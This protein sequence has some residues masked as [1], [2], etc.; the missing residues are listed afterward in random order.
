MSFERTWVLSAALGLC[1][2]GGLAPSSPP[3][4]RAGGLAVATV[5]LV[6]LGTRH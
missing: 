2:L 6:S 5:I 4:A 1:L 3:D